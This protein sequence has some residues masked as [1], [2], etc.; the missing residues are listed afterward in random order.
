MNDP[1]LPRSELEGA[2][3]QTLG[4]R[5]GRTPLLKDVPSQEFTWGVCCLLCFPEHVA[6]TQCCFL[7][8]GKSDCKAEQVFLNS[9][10]RVEK[11]GG[12]SETL[13]TLHL[14][15]GA[16]QWSLF[17]ERTLLCGQDPWGLETAGCPK[18]LRAQLWGKAR[19]AGQSNRDSY[20][21][22]HK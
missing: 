9:S 19:E 14:S 5:S 2:E 3:T 7:P 18:R 15:P 16:G 13:P 22:A 8:C 17:L 10:V 4:R 12:P 21:G 20:L 11:H 1:I 6:L